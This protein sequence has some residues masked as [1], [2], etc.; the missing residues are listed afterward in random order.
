M[1]H[2]FPG[3]A[4]GRNAVYEGITCVRRHL[5]VNPVTSRP[6]LFIHRKRCP[7]LVREL[8]TYRWRQGT[9][10]ERNPMD[11]RPEPLKKDDHACDALRYILL[12]EEQYGGG[13]YGSKQRAF[14]PRQYG[15]Q[16]RN[17]GP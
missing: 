5:K 12:S 1:H 8:G 13:H 3:I 4:S 14:E 2:G 6:R 11:P 9:E 7:N 10:S 16:H 17:G 15:I